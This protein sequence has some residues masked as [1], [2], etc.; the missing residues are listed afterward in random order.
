MNF[1]PAG[2]LWRRVKRSIAVFDCMVAV[3]AAATMTAALSVLVLIIVSKRFLRILAKA[4]KAK[5][6]ARRFSCCWA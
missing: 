5:S 1:H 2:A 6:A 4:S 3:E